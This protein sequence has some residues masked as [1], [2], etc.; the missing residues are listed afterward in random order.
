MNPRL[1]L[2]FF[3]LETQLR[4]VKLAVSKVKGQLVLGV[5]QSVYFSFGSRDIMLK[6]TQHFTVIEHFRLR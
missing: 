2:K 1:L 4:F 6:K 3:K 5:N